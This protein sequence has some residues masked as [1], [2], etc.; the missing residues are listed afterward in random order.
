[1]SLSE[2]DKNSP[3]F[4]SASSIINQALQSASYICTFF[5]LYLFEASRDSLSTFHSL[6]FSLLL[7]LSLAPYKMQIQLNPIYIKSLLDPAAPTQNNTNP[8]FTNNK[9][10]KSERSRENDRKKHTHTETIWFLLVQFTLII[11]RTNE[12]TRIG[13]SD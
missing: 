4:L 13:F 10:N 8:I 12:I 5:S 7:S 2:L 9:R 3:L 1:M 6:S 11:I